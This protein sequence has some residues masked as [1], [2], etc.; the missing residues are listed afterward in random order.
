LVGR[1]ARINNEGKAS[2]LW[3]VIAGVE[4]LVVNLIPPRSQDKEANAHA[5]PALI[6]VFNKQ[7]HATPETCA[8]LFPEA[9]QLEEPP[10][11]WLQRQDGTGTSLVVQYKLETLVPVCPRHVPAPL[12]ITRLTASA[13]LH[14]GGGA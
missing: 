1:D 8:A 10:P 13:P 2:G 6:V 14:T 11:N 9:T 3:K 7:E 5:K 4:F 12:A